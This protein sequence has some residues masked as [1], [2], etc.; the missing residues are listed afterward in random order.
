SPSH[1]DDAMSTTLRSLVG[2]LALPLLTLVACRSS[3]AA[4]T[5]PIP[6]VD[7]K[8]DPCSDFDAF[9]NGPWRA[10]NPIPDQLSRWGRRAAAKETNR[11]QVQELLQDFARREDLPRGSVERLL[12][13]HFAS[14]M[15]ESRIEGL[16]VTPLAPLL[17]EID[18]IRSRSDLQRNIRR[19]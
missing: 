17:D 11:R 4:P 13:D 5:A 15:D 1:R 18:A 16:G 14:C 7:R 8:V 6:D 9:A 2:L 3:T 12:A 19:L 10:A